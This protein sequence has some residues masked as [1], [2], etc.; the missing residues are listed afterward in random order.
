MQNP[1]SILAALGAILLWASLAMTSKLLAGIPP[2]YQLT[3]GFLVGA[4]PV[5]TGARAFP[6][7][8]V[9]GL[10]VAGLFGYHLFLFT[11]F[12]LAPPVEANLIN[13]LWPMVMVLMAP[14][15]YVHAHLSRWH[16]VG[17][18]LALLGVVLLM[19]FQRVSFT[20]ATVAGY[21]SAAA[22]A[23]TWPVYSLLKGRTPQVELR[24]TG[25]IC[26]VAALLSLA[27]HLTLE[28]TPTPTER[29]WW[30]L[31]WMGVG[32]F[33]AAFYLWDFAIKKGDPRVIG[34]L[35]YLTPVL[36]TVLLVFVAK[37]SASPATWVAMFLMT[38]GSLVGGRVSR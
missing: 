21:L 5:V 6:P 38:L 17:A 3:I 33:G 7:L 19:S 13:Y 15:F 10:G 14:L 1:V 27:T 28:V 22:A 34:A 8:K 2:F 31:L 35:S 29:E 12:R 9:L 30:L 24:T 25:G 18:G 36:S 37:Q 23:L 4:L 26:L 20:P 16:F 32:P 11:A